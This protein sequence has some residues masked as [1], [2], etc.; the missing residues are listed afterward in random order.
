[1]I[2]TEWSALSREEVEAEAEAV[3]PGRGEEEVGAV[4]GLDAFDER[5][6]RCK[7]CATARERAR[8]E[9]FP[10]TESVLVSALRADASYVHE[11]TRE[12]LLR[13]KRGGIMGGGRLTTHE[14]RP[15]NLTLSPITHR[16]Q[17]RTLNRFQSSCSSSS[18]LS[19]SLLLLPLVLLQLRLLTIMIVA[20]VMTNQADLAQQK[21][22]RRV[23]INP[24]RFERELVPQG[25]RRRDIDRS[26]GKDG[27]VQVRGRGVVGGHRRR[28]CGRWSGSAGG[29][30][31]GGRAKDR[32]GI[33]GEM[34]RPTQES[35]LVLCQQCK[36]FS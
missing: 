28:C 20:M 24:R 13:P 34:S 19:L 9:V 27:E 22:P 18:S 2:R 32:S 36:L 25:G 10:G 8:A 23:R 3:E 33:G 1:M 7:D 5:D 30:G 6:G 16:E 4:R 14:P 35:R 12:E 31:R 21:L 15:V 11:A 26:E 17:H 29:R